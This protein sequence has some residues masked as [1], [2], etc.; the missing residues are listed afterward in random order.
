[1]KKNIISIKDKEGDRGQRTVGYFREESQER[2]FWASDFWPELWVKLLQTD[3]QGK[4][5][6]NR[7]N[8]KFK[9]FSVFKE[10]KPSA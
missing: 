3:P 4:K 1:M 5:I 6:L 7:R 9:E 10:V 2:S 8:G